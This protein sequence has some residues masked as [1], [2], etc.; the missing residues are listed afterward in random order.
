[1]LPDDVGYLLVDAS[2]ECSVVRNGGVLLVLVA[3]AA[4]DVRWVEQSTESD[5][6]LLSPGDCVHVPHEVGVVVDRVLS[7]WQEGCY[8]NS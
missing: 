8:N 6:A 5:V 3:G 1:M 2:V 4:G 7:V